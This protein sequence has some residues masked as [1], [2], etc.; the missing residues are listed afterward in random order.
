MGSPDNGGLKVEPGCTHWAK[1]GFL[2]LA[3]YPTCPEL[4]GQLFQHV[5][6]HLSVSL[7]SVDQWSINGRTH[8]RMGGANDFIQL[9]TTLKAACLILRAAVCTHFLAYT[10]PSPAR[11]QDHAR[12]LPIYKQAQQAAF[13]AHRHLRH[14]VA[15]ITYL[16]SIL[17]VW[18]NSGSAW[19]QVS[20]AP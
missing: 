15:L 12:W 11:P 14:E 8:H 16:A 3:M 9:Q 20:K 4:H 13:V 1:P 18:S 2:H 6:P 7:V 17:N 5:C 19:S 10:P